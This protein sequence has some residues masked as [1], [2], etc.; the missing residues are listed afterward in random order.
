MRL[1]ACSMIDNDSERR[2]LVSTLKSRRAVLLSGAGSSMFVGY[3]SWGEL[4]EQMKAT[5]APSAVRTDSMSDMGFAR[6]IVDEIESNNCLQD[7]YNFL[8]RTFE[9]RLDR[10]KQ[11]DDFHVAL[12]Q[13]GFC[14][15][16]TTNY[17]EVIESAVSEAYTTEMRPWR[18]GP[19]DLCQERSYRVFDFFQSLTSGENPRWVLHLHGHHLNPKG[20]ILTEK[21]YQTKYGEPP[22]YDT[23]TKRPM[24]IILDSL[25]RKVLWTLFATHPLVF[26]GFSLNDDFFVHMLHVVREDF[27][28][29]SDLTHFA[30]VGIIDDA[31]EMKAREYLRQ[32]NT[33]PVFYRVTRHSTGEE[34]HSDLKRLVYELAEKVG[35]P[36]VSGSIAA[37]NKRMLEL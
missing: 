37:I 16:V 34:D 4:L 22:T 2:Q 6:K 23:Y 18:C 36:I 24:N 32:R 5:F 28:L 21:D 30:L 3:P 31:D 15:L 1:P 20:I 25:H 26:V 29:G 12:V 27:E 19:L 10:L 7:Y 9:P 11:H 33:T 14:G 35:A 13:L 8:D 17:E